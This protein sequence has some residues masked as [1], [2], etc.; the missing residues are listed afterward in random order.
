MCK[1]LLL[2]P[3]KQAT[4]SVIAKCASAHFQTKIGTGKLGEFQQKTSLKLQIVR[5]VVRPH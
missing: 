3:K 1:W 2:T 4:Q 5:E